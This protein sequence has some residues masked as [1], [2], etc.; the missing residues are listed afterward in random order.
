MDY[1]LV[2][3]SLGQR[4]CPTPAPKHI[5][6]STIYLARTRQRS[7]VSDPQN[8]TFTLWRVHYNVQ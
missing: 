5:S 1:F 6:I 2:R 3:H 8:E 7:P 4:S